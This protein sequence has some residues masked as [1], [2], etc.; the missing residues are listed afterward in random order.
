MVFLCVF[1]TF[2]FLFAV[3]G[4][5]VVLGTFLGQHGLARHGSLRGVYGSLRRVFGSLRR[6]CGGVAEA[7]GLRKLTEG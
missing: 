4:L 1:D 6:L 7:E 2:T 3:V 5:C